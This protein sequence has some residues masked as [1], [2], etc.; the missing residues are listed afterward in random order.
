MLSRERTLRE[1]FSPEWTAN[2]LAYSAIQGH[3]L[4]KAAHSQ[5]PAE[6]IGRS[7]V[8]RLMLTADSTLDIATSLEHIRAARADYVRLLKDCMRAPDGTF[9]DSLVVPGEPTP[10]R[11]AINLDLAHNNPL[12]LDESNPWKD[13]F[14]SLDLRKTIQKDVERTFPDMDYFRAPSTQR[15]LADIL[16]VYAKSHPTIS[17]RQGMHEL[18]APVLWALDHDALDESQ[19]PQIAEFLSREHVS[20]DAWAI[21]SSIMLAA[22]PW[23]EWQEPKTQTPWVP[24]INEICAKI[25]GEYL[26]ACD[27]VLAARLSDLGIEPQM[28]G[29]RWLRLLFTREFP[30]RD[31]LMLWDALFATDPS[32]QIVPWICVAM[33]IRIRNLLIS[34]DYTTA[35]TYLL[36]YPPPPS[37]PQSSEAPE[38]LLETHI[39]V[40][41]ALSLRANPSVSTGST[42][43]LQNR[44]LLG[45]PI[46]APSPPPPERRA[47]R[48]RSIGAGSDS[49]TAKGRPAGLKHVPEGSLSGLAAFNSLGERADV[50]AKGLRDIG[51]TVGSRVSEIRKNL[52]DL[53]R[54]PSTTT[55]DAHVFPYYQALRGD[56][57]EESVA[58]VRPSIV[59]SVK[60]SMEGLVRPPPIESRS[61]GESQGQARLPVSA[62]RTPRTRFEVEREVG[63]LKA[64]MRR[65]G[66]GVDA[67]LELVRDGGE[68]GRQEALENLGYIQRVLSGAVGPEMVDDNKLL[69]PSFV[70]RREEQ[71]RQDEATRVQEVAR[72]EEEVEKR[73]EQRVLAPPPV[74]A[75]DPLQASPSVRPAQLVQTSPPRV[76]TTRAPWERSEHATMHS[77]LAQGTNDPL[78]AGSLE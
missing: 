1:I 7:V 33:L 48:R 65:L 61:P 70:A 59:G 20:S 5:P 38:P 43:V 34:A 66:Q 40:Q 19:D 56:D 32:L 62:G 47:G 76:R 29:I 16:F 55:T 51:G 28:Y 73:E 78:G 67:A 74:L 50:I 21:F 30:W 12:G 42:V 9:P 3:L 57:R 18:L 75:P 23:Y 17:Y 10:R 27:P 58:A 45:I 26:K 44:S 39:L 8:W 37:V 15:M 53:V 69:G 2:K 36:R 24:P 4:V 22:G 68:Q 52:P 11:T 13:Y 6:L 71:K 35:L 49:R 41:Q 77:V 46:E 72:V 60:R 14:A 54:T 31:A 64:L 63:E 25:G